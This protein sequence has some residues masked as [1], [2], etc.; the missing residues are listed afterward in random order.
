MIVIFALV[1]IVEIIY[2]DKKME[3]EFSKL[4]VVQMLVNNNNKIMKLIDSKI[5]VIEGEEVVCYRKRI[6][7]PNQEL[8]RH[9]F[10]Y[11]IS[12]V[13]D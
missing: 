5:F 10:D 2:K 11:T 3:K 4:E 1:F 13:S 9:S 8:S 7:F 12:E 6:V